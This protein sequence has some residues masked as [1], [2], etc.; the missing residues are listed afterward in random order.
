[1]G[2]VE[3]FLF[4]NRLKR[5]G[6]RTLWNVAEEKIFF[7]ISTEKKKEGRIASLFPYWCYPILESR[8]LDASYGYC[9]CTLVVV[10]TVL[11]VEL[12]FDI[13]LHAFSIVTVES[14]VGIGSRL[15]FVIVASRSVADQC[16]D[17]IAQT[18]SREED[19]FAFARDDNIL[20]AA[21]FTSTIG[22][23]IL[24]EEVEST[25]ECGEEYRCSGGIPTVVS[26]ILFQRRSNNGSF[27]PTIVCFDTVPSPWTY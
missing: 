21:L 26:S 12:S 3:T 20:V 10:G 1:M 15:A 9:T 6:A 2:S 11:P 25:F 5:Y 16:T 8:S 14:A 24:S 18:C 27:S 7:A 22:V 17:V 13:C 23:I 19:G 4:R